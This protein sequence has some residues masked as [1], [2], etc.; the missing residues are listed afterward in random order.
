MP[1]GPPRPPCV[2]GRCG[3][4]PLPAA[5]SP[6]HPVRRQYLGAACRS[7]GGSLPCRC[8]SRLRRIHSRTAAGGG[9]SASKA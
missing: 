5:A 8:H 7:A 9:C 2:W 4:V 1:A 6:R 3:R